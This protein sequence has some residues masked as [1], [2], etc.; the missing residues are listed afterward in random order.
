MYW[1]AEPDSRFGVLGN[2]DMQEAYALNEDGKKLASSY[3][4][5]AKKSSERVIFGNPTQIRRLGD[6]TRC[7]AFL[8]EAEFES[9]DPECDCR[10]GSGRARSREPGL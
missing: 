2:A 9:I 8:M 7:R 4:I 10:T 5:R 3:L 1:R 6:E